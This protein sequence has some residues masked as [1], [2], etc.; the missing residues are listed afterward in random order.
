MFISHDPNQIEASARIGAAVVELHA[1]LYS[2]LHS[3]G[4]FDAAEAEL[5]AL[6]KGAAFAHQ[7][8]LEVH[9]GHGLTYENVA[10]IA[11]I[12]ELVELNIGHF[13][14]GEAIF[15]GLEEAILEMRRRMDLARAAG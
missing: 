1:G 15:I 6:R 7:L 13:L 9:A 5:A 8:G 14:I 3:D 4:H 10:P 2:D 11:R 12:P